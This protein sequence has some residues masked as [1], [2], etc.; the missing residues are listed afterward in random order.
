MYV[1]IVSAAPQPRTT[2]MPLAPFVIVSATLRSSAPSLAYVSTRRARRAGGGGTHS[3]RAPPMD[4]LAT[5]PQRRR[6]SRLTGGDMDPRLFGEDRTRRPEAARRPRRTSSR[7]LAPPGPPNSD[8]GHLPR[9]A[10]HERRAG[11]N[12]GSGHSPSDPARSTTIPRQARIASTALI[13]TRVPTRGRGRDLVFTNSSHHQ[14]VHEVGA[15]LR[16]TAKARRRR[17]GSRVRGSAWW[18]VGVQWHPGRLTATAELGSPVVRRV[19][20]AVRAAVGTELGQV[21]RRQRAS[22]RTCRINRSGVCTVGKNR[23]SLTELSAVRST[24][25]RSAAVA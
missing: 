19:R 2:Q 8:A 1:Q 13:S 15:D 20:R 10:G 5:A 21:A 25:N 6:R 24:P 7:S 12:A 17:R 22:S 4:P 11:R 18:M 16:V 3:G 14:S 9:H 23:A